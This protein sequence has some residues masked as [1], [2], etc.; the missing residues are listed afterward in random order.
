MKNGMIV[1]VFISL[2]F[3]GGCKKKLG[4]GGAKNNNVDNYPNKNI[5]MIVPANAGTLVDIAARDVAS[6]L[7]LGK[8]ITVMNRGGAGQTIGSAEV[9]AAAGDGYTLGVLGYSGLLT[10]PIQLGLEYSVDD[11]RFIGIT[12]A[13]PTNMLVATPQSGYTSW[14]HIVNDAKAGKE[15]TYTSGNIG[16]ITHLAM[17][18][19]M[20]VSGVNIKFVPF[21]GSA[22]ANAALQ[23]GHVDLGILI[24]EPN[25]QKV[26][27]GQLIPLVMYTPER[28]EEFPDVPTST[29]LGVEAK[30]YDSLVVLCVPKATPD[31]IFDY[32]KEKADTM[33]KDNVYIQAREKMGAS[34]PQIV[35]E[36]ELTTMV[37][38]AK[39]R[40]TALSDNAGLITR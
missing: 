5:T 10:K 22:E 13:P 38:E 12:Q 27:D 29:E 2:A 8:P 26:R 20:Q 15:I 3:L 25:M 7:D 17:I 18:E 23:G 35:S 39:I 9:A 21:N 40:F 32:I 30:N 24:R 34:A 14:E 1:F 28:I 19:L 4:T 36:G 16:S 33:F 6:H 31:P 11:F 37:N